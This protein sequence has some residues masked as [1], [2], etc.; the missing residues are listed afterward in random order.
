MCAAQEA[1][2]RVEWEA[3][4]ARLRALQPMEPAAEPMDTQESSTE[5]DGVASEGAADGGNGEEE[6]MEAEA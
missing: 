4:C 3:E 5:V 2:L 1:V 6:P